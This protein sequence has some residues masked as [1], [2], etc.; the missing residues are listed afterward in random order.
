MSDAKQEATPEAGGTRT[1]TAMDMLRG[2]GGGVAGTV[3][4]LIGMYSTGGFISEDKARTMI[5]REAP[6]VEDRKQML[7]VAERVATIEDSQM[8]LR[9][10]FNQEMR[11]RDGRIVSVIEKNT[12]AIVELK[13]ELARIRPA[14]NNPPEE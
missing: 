14:V 4:I 1:K 7:A 12:D 2:G 5:E 11:E 9:L 13:L 3:A 8:K 10:D 6:Y